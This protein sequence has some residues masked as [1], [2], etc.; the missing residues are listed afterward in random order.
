MNKIE[1]LETAYQFYPQNIN[2]LN[3][4]MKINP[5]YLNSTENV[6]L[7]KLIGV[8]FN[9][10]IDFGK[11]VID[12]LYE[13]GVKIELRDATNI[14]MGD[15]AFNIQHSGFFSSQ[16]LKYYPLCFVFSGLIPYYH[17]YIVDIDI[18]FDNPIVKNSYKWNKNNGELLDWKNEKKFTDVFNKVSK[19]IEQKLGYQKFPDNLIYEKIPN[20]C[21]EEIN[22]NKFTFFN[23]FFMNNFYC[24]P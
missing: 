14:N 16:K 6:N 1:F 13:N 19:I 11:T 4:D 23:A 15:K 22:S 20:I 12:T 3:N 17:F 18:S 5:I 21:N 24:L 7:K 8:N 2:Y 9:K 10:P